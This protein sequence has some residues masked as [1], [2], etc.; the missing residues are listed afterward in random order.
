MSC[1][2]SGQKLFTNNY[3]L[4][5]WVDDIFYRLPNYGFTYY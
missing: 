3:G 2:D 4:L 1:Y 5:T